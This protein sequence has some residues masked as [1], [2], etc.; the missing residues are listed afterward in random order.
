MPTIEFDSRGIG[1]RNED[2]WYLHFDE[3]TGEFSVEH[4]WSYLP[5][6]GEGNNGTAKYSLS[7]FKEKD[8]D[9]YKQLVELITTKLFANNPLE[10]LS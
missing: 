8:A 9:H 3:Q 1:G 5:V 4:E 10:S 2:W 7:E 6:K